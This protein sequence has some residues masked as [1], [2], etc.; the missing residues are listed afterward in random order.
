[1]TISQTGGTYKFQS[2][3][4]RR[5]RALGGALDDIASQVQAVRTQANLGQSGPNPAPAAP[6]ALSVSASGGFVTAKVTYANPPAGISYV[7]QYSSTPD[8]QDPIPVELGSQPVLHQYLSGLT[9]HFR[10]A[11]KLGSSATSPWTY[12]GSSAAPTAVTA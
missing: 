6:T 2:E 9:L 1:M 8:F 12:F 3:L 7:V 5:D 10:V 11:A 4:Q